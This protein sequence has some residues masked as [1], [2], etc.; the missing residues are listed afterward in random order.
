MSFPVLSRSLD[1]ELGRLM[2]EDPNPQEDSLPEAGE[3]VSEDTEDIEELI[4]QSKDDPALKKTGRRWCFTV[5]ISI[6]EWQT[7]VL[8]RKEKIMEKCK[9]F[10]WQHEKTPK[11]NKH[12]VQGFIHLNSPQRFTAIKKMLGLA[13][14][15]WFTPSRG[16]DEQNQAYCTKEKSREAPG[17]QWGAPVPG[18]GARSD[19]KGA[20]DMAMQPGMT[21]HQFLHSDHGPMYLKFHGAIDKILHLNQ[22]VRD[23]PSKFYILWGPTGSGKSVEAN[24]L[25]NKLAKQA[26]VAVWWKGDCGTKWWCGMPNRAVVVL[27]E[28]SPKNMAITVLLRLLDWTPRTEGVCHVV[29]KSRG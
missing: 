19:L 12:H 24:R 1:E 3:P 16:S 14:A 27:D 26:E 7:L 4:E 25:A 28:F 11:T 2:G 23:T 22:Q 20:F 10:V 21:V 29:T 13:C 18:Q 9:Y 17:E 8:P 15:V 5:F 6:E